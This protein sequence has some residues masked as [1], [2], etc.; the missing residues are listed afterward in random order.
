MVTRLEQGWTGQHEQG[1]AGQ[2]EQ[3]WAGQH[4]QHW[5]GQH[6][7]GW[8]GQHEQG[9]AGQHE[10]VFGGVRGAC[11]HTCTPEVIAVFYVVIIFIALN[12][13]EPQRLPTY[14]VNVFS[15]KEHF[16]L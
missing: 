3:G 6:E 12:C 5:V 7:Q 4:E 9:C 16:V 8:A 10:R 14:S 15:F 13:F 2:H 11:M 1:W